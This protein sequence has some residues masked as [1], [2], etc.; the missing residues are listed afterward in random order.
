MAKRLLLLGGGHT[1]LGVLE[2]LTAEPMRD[3][4]VTLLSA[5]PRQ[6]YSGMLPGWVAG[7]YTIDECSVSLVD[8][9]AR[10][11]VAFHRGTVV[12]LDL[13]EHVAVAA[14]GES[15]GFDV[16]SIDTGSEPAILGLSG[17][18][19]HALPIRPIEAFISAWPGVVADWTDK[20]SAFELVIVGGGA[21]AIELAFAARQRAWSEGATHVR[22]TLVSREAIPLAGFQ[23]AAVKRTV[24]LLRKLGIAWRGD[25]GVAEIQAGRL[26]LEDDRIVPF[27]ACLLATGAAAPTWPRRA[28]LATDEGGFVRVDATLQSVSHPRVFAAGDVA[29]LPEPRPKSG[30]FAVRASPALGHNL[31]AALAQGKPCEWQ[32]QKRALYLLSTGDGRAIAVWGSWSAMGRWVW[33]WKDRID[34][35][36]VARFR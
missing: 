11:G 14:D 18:K 1:H 3:C 27:D 32:P 8:L 10:A 23:P 4:E 9:A 17:A 20:T 30:V 36:F 22:V 5:Y 29:A 26:L 2:R 19:D 16:L 33:R 25:S 21:A 31:Y 34:R 13:E 7:H 6:I 28:G 12:R 35:R 15:F 24:R